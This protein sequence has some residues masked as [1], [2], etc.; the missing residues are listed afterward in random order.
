MISPLKTYC[1]SCLKAVRPE[2][3]KGFVSFESKRLHRIEYTPYIHLKM[4]Q[5]GQQSFDLVPFFSIFLSIWGNF[6]AGKPNN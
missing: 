5:M 2:K 3:K 6:K 4:E 1:I